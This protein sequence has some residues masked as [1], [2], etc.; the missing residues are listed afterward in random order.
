MMQAK[1]EKSATRT[2]PGQCEQFAVPQKATDHNEGTG[3]DRFVYL[4]DTSLLPR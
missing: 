4:A 2:L 1:A 3:F